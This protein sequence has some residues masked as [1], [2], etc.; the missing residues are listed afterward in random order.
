MGFWGQGRGST[1]QAG[2]RKASGLLFA[3]Y[4]FLGPHE[5]VLR[6]Y[7]G[8]GAS[9]HFWWCWETGKLRTEASSFTEMTD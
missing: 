7:S 1:V 9:I 4:L 6:S 2:A 3:F 8:L 5:V